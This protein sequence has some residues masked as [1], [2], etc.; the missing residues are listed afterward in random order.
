MI[1]VKQVESLEE[2]LGIL[3]ELLELFV[4]LDG[5]WEQGLT[6]EEFAAKVISNFKVQEY[7]YQKSEK[8]DCFLALGF[9]VDNDCFVWLFYFAQEIREQSKKLLFA[10]MNR[11]RAR[12]I[13]R[14]RFTTNILTSSY[15]RWAEKLGAVKETITYKIEL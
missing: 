10:M 15:N 5:K 4:K 1:N 2:L 7:Y 13:K 3:P 11:I 8:L 9:N 6:K 12:G 14:V